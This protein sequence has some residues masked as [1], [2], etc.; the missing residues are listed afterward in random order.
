MSDAKITEPSW[1]VCVAGGGGGGGAIGAGGG[2][3]GRTSSP[4][5]KL[6]IRLASKLCDRNFCS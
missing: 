5:P 6:K 1:Q 3:G 2:G 4:P